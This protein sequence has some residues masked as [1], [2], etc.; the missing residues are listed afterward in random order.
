MPSRNPNDLHPELQKR[1]EWMR[2]EWGE[3]YPDAPSPFLT[4]TYRPAT[5]QQAKV[6]SGASNAMPMQSLHNF[7]PALAFDVAFDPDQSDGIGND[8]TWTFRWFERWGVLAEEIGLEWGGRWEG[9]V[10]GPHVQWPV[11]WQV[12]QVGGSLPPLPPLP[13]KFENPPLPVKTLH[14]MTKD[15]G[16]MIYGLDADVPARIVGSKLYANEQV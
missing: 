9:L 3:R 2:R 8:V 1:W 12:A 4:T 14:V 15:G 7:V 16:E 6:D 11:P 5:E 13:N 10:D